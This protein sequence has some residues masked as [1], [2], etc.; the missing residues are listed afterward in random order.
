[1]KKETQAFHGYRGPQLHMHDD[2]C[3][4]DSL[5]D[6]ADG[7]NAPEGM[8]PTAFSQL[9]KPKVSVALQC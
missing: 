3:G 7:C 1:M 6:R 4:N 5:A 2:G 9:L 8:I